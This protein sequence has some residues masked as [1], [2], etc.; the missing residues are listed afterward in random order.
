[1]NLINQVEV[2]FQFFFSFFFFQN[3]FLKKNHFKAKRVEQLDEHFLIVRNLYNTEGR[4]LY[5]L[6][7]NNQVI[8]L[9]KK[10]SIWYI[11]LRAI[12]EKVKLYGITK[13]LTFFFSNF[14]FSNNN[15]IPNQ[16]N[17][18]IF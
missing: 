8:G 7:E 16:N 9:L 6:N 1:L 4:V 3:F 13:G 15:N 17:Y 18:L 11:I 14:F 12:R 5:F 10:K 2:F